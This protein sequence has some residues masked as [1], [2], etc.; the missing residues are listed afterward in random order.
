MRISRRG[1]LKIAGATTAT[2]LLADFEVTRPVRAYAMEL[3][4]KGAKETPTICPYCSVGCGQIAH[5]RD[6]RLINLEGDPDHPISRG[7]LCPK[8]SA[9]FE[10]TINERRQN[11]VLYRAPGSAKWEEKSL[12]WAME[13]IAQKY[14]ETRDATFLETDADGNRVN[15]TPG[16]TWIGSACC[17][18]EETY[19]FAKL[20]RSTGLV[21]FEHQARI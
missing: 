8:G 6:G 19:L 7:R 3:P 9:T 4:I 17:D 2:T 1:F 20:A 10:L 15:R 12:S 5:V 14:K 16:I 13:R 21:Y 18:N 11:K